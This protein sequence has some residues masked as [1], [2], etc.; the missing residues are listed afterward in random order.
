MTIS[1][2]APPTGDI[3]VQAARQALAEM[4]VI[5][6]I[7]NPYWWLGRLSVALAD[8]VAVA[9]P[10]GMD[11]GQ[12][13]VLAAAL[14]DAVNYRDPWGECTDCDARTDGLC[15]DHSADLSLTDAYL[16]LANE[17]GLELDR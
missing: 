8:L 12:R 13:E 6:D 4:P 9:S 10:G 3:H 1:H 7:E 2:P 15:L 11:N 16:Q 5:A 17:L 14:S